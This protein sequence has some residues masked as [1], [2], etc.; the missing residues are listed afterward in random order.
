M[1]SVI[2]FK[3][4]DRSLI[5]LVNDTGEKNLS[6]PIVQKDDKLYAGQRVTYDCIWFGEYLQ[7]DTNGDG[8]VNVLDKKQKIK[9]RILQVENNKALILSD[10]ILD[11]KWYI[12]G[13]NTSVTWENSRMRSWLNGYSEMENKESLDFSKDSFINTAFNL[14]EKKAITVTRV[15]TPDNEKKELLVEV[16][17]MIE[18][19][20]FQLMNAGSLRMDLPKISTT[21]QNKQKSQNMLHKIEKKWLCQMQNHFQAG[22]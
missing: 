2:Y 6:N 3:K 16:I 7:K 12:E 15:V 13:C 18:C 5:K 11:I 4:L 10:K 21:R 19:F 22:Y 8:K 17:L 9:W 14:E 20:C 1:P